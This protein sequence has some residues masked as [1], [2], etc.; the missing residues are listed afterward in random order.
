[1]AKDTPKQSLKGPPKQTLN[2]RSPALKGMSDTTSDSLREAVERRMLH[3]ETF[4]EAWDRIFAM[5][6][7]DPDVRRLHE[8]KQAMEND[9]IGRDPDSA[10]KRFSKAEA[11]RMY[12]VIEE[13]KQAKIL[14]DM[15]ENIPDNYVL[16]TEESDLRRVAYELLAEEII[17][18][19]VESTGVDVWKDRLVGHVLSV[20]S[21]DTHYYIPTG[22]RDSRPQL[23]EELVLKHL[24][25]IYED[26]SIMKIAHNFKYDYQMLQRAGIGVK[27]RIWDTQEAMK[28]LNENESS[29]A[30]K[31]LVSK[32]LRIESYGYADLFGKNT[33]F[34]EVDLDTA[35]AYAAKDGDVTY[36]L[37]QFQRHHLAK[38]GN[39][40]EYFETVE[41]PLL[42]IVAD[43]EMGGYKIDREF[44]SQY[45]EELRVEE[46]ELS[47]KVFGVLGDINLNSP[48]QLKKAIEEHIGKSIEN[49]NAKQTLKPL[50]KEHRIISDLLRYREISKL[51]STYID[52]L[53][54]LV[55]EA[56]GHIHAGYYQNG[57]K[58]GRFSS[59]E[60][61][62]GAG[63]TVSKTGLINMQNQP[64]EARKMFVA[65]EG[66]YIVNADFSA[67][68]VRII[69]S[70]SKEQV[71]LDAF[72][73]GRDAY[74]TLASEFFGKPYED[75][76]KLPD[77]S[78]TEER[79][80]MKVVLLSSMYGA[81]KYGLA[82][83]L[84]IS[85]DEAEKFRVDFFKK[86]RK[87]DAFINETQRFAN[88]NGFVWI[89]DKQ[90]KRR[91]PEARGNMRRYD[92]ARNRAMRQGPNARIQGLAALQTKV[93]MIALDALCKRK[94]WRI[95]A[96]IHDEVAILTDDKIS[97]E[98][99]EEIDRVMTETYLLDGV[100]NATDIEIQRRWGDSITADEYLSGKE[101]PQL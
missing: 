10:S 24:R 2:I 22:H 32:Y 23:P 6:N 89:G 31:P 79:K 29:Y 77:G 51:L 16:I 9:E 60:D 30:L 18:F 80:Q 5:K 58:T 20:T 21:T 36:K 78:D 85:V 57:T 73:E 70:E 27:G 11:L 1:M 54:K 90:R 44:A 83:S 41:M 40:L 69:A 98:D 63:T 87:I 33:G 56:S 59:G 50:A 37:Y 13:R 68:E 88:R 99:I 15:R 25:P 95:W 82:E 86:Y 3:K 45:G 84:G 19:D 64:D 39:I 35:L 55:K 17:V 101:V 81:S 72:R 94:G 26:D 52:A 76:Y 62:D 7:S 66:H 100:D 75:C 12:A 71:L 65:P 4:E 42:P 74:A 67:Q 96:T 49:T 38:H 47:E 48:P 53:P 46:A 97:K 28:L 14:A 43:M 91:L 8:V 34:D 93:T 92:P 61:K